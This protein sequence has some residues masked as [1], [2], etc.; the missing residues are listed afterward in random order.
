MLMIEYP[1]MFPQVIDI[2]SG[3]NAEVDF[4]LE[5]GSARQFFSLL[6]SNSSST[7]LH[8]AQQLDRE[9][10]D[11]YSFRIFATDRGFPSSLMGQTQIFITVA[12]SWNDS[13]KLAP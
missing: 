12:V 13:T 2:D 5:A 11:M 6:H 7:Q 10:Q 3:Q 8:L 4:S 9:T 1:W